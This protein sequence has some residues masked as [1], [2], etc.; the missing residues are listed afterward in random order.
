MQWFSEKETN[1]QNK[2]KINKQEKVKK[3][4]NQKKTE[5]RE[6]MADEELCNTSLMELFRKKNY[7][8]K[9]LELF[10]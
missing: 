7:R 3:Q 8:L 5:K 2:L 6:S 1:K 9:D 4:A 10:L